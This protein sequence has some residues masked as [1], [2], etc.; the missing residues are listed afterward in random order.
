MAV[1]SQRQ[2]TQGGRRRQRH[3]VGRLPWKALR[4]SCDP[5]TIPA[6]STEK[7][8]L[9]DGEI[10]G[11]ARALG[12]LEMSMRVRDLDYNVYVSGSP[13]TGK[14]F[15]VTSYLKK[16]AKDLP[17]PRDW[18]Y[19]Y[20]FRDPDRPKALWLPPGR[21]RAFRKEM[22]GLMR[23][24]Q[25]ALEK[26]FQGDTYQIRREA[27]VNQAQKER[28][29]LLRDLERKVEAGGHLLELR[30]EGMTIRPARGG[31]ALSDE[32]VKA[33]P[34]ETRARL[35]SVSE[36]LQKEMSQA[37]RG[38]QVVERLAREEE[39]SLREK[40]A[41]ET[42]DPLFQEAQD[43]YAQVPPVKEYLAQVEEDI[44]AS[45]DALYVWDETDETGQAGGGPQA[46]W[47]RYGVNLIVDHA[48]EVGAP[49]VIE[50][51]P[52]YM[53]LFGGIE[54]KA[55]MGVLVTD[56]TLIRP[57]A[58]HRANGGFLVLQAT[59]LMQW[60]LSWESLK[61]ALRFGE[62]KIEEI[63]EQLGMVATKG[64]SPE[65]IPLDCK[66]VLIGPPHLYQLLYG[67]DDYFPKIFKVKADLDD[68]M[69]RGPEEVKTFCSYLATVCR[70]WGLLPIDRG[71]MARLVEYASELA[72]HQEKLTLQLSEVED[73]VREAHIWAVDGGA[74]CIGA[75]EVER[76]IQ[77]KVRRSSLPEERLQEL[78]EE[79]FLKIETRGAVVGS[80]NGLSVYDL[81]DH[82]FARPTRV[83]ATISL[84]RE[85]VLDVEREAKLGGN[86]HTKG[87]LILTGFLRWRFAQEKPLSLSAS[88]CFEQSY[89]DIDGDSA[90]GAEICAL[91][92]SLADA[93]VRQGI[94][95]TGAVSQ[96]GEMLP[97]GDVTRKIEGFYQVCKLQGFTGTQGV[98]IP[99]RNVRDL[100]LSQE[101]LN[102]VRKR[103]FHVYAV[104][105]V[106][107]AMEILTGMPAGRRLRD[108]SFEP[109][110]L[111][112]RIDRRL[113]RL[114]ELYRETAHEE[115]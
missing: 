54:R 7:M 67:L 57:G 98:L 44:V 72:G 12:A 94:A 111:N 16:V 63:G 2:M 96:H 51:N 73:I 14:T 29:N 53:N 115:E 65:P 85:G 55:E 91:L 62:I 3:F 9:L 25:T 83:T 46:H 77:E 105:D 60:P 22:E 84:G 52:T 103:Q 5:S 95:L 88:L 76:A 21:G 34:E 26:S 41:R 1:K 104:D 109:G 68:Q 32:E 113:R 58:I 13:R 99:S 35:Q 33:L 61:R 80:V 47:Q 93:P 101:V 97:V 38:I 36:E 28:N 86:I 100:M 37:V 11:Q 6:Q 20:N 89:E 71:G 23:E 81:G 18:V 42:L 82:V 8:P 75:A 4:G 30:P 69:P 74:K 10:V 27:I 114:N 64:L 108:G 45:L 112:D 87:I 50:P 39:A 24:A 66:V 90:S 31:K 107:Q 70:K 102:A 106:D 48:D 59:D 78:I 79:G 15:L 49:V 92:S 56:F 17:A 110:S 19:V 43:R 40:V